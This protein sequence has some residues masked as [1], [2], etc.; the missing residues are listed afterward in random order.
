MSI[1]YKKALRAIPGKPDAEKKFYPELL[2]MGKNTDLDAIAY[3]IKEKSSLSK[4]DI[5][6][7]LSNF[8]EAM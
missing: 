5:L 8:V 1:V 2:S 4:G 6:S 7:V 3:E